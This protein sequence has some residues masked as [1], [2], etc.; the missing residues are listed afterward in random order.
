M[1]KIL[2]FLRRKIFS[3]LT[4][5][6]SYEIN[7]LKKDILEETRLQNGVRIN[8]VAQKQLFHFYKSVLEQ[9]QNIDLQTTGFRNYSQ[10]EEDGLLLF[11]LAAIGIKSRSFVDIGSANGINSN[12]ANLAL[13]FGFHGLF[14]DGDADLINEGIN[15]YKTHPDTWLYPPK[16]ECA[17]VTRENINSLIKTNGISGEIDLLSI[18]IDGKD[19]WIWDALETVDPRVVI[20]ETHIEYGMRSVVVPYDKN[21]SFSDSDHKPH[22]ASVS[23]MV[24]LAKSKGY[25]LVGANKFGFNLIFVKGDEG[26]HHLP[27]IESIDI[28][29]HPRYSERLYEQKSI[30]E[31]I[32][33]GFLSSVD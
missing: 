4:T 2:R 26:T 10:F 3:S 11:I 27:T 7:C 30:D 21:Y 16:F 32:D 8:S 5:Q 28:T 18:D 22:G 14:I 20:I 6:F 1:K 12:C 19:Y 13:N 23:A 15:Y 31:W 17:K 9:G 24:K 25:R 33:L 29:T